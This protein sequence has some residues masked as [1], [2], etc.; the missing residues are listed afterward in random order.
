MDWIK[1]AAKATHT[2]RET[3][4]E[5]LRQGKLPFGTAVLCDGRWAYIPFPPLLKQYLNIDYEEEP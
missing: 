4:R 3:I 2:S 1:E 5:A